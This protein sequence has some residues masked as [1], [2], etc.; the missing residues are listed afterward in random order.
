MT[1]DK[2]LTYLQEQTENGSIYVWGGQGQTGSQITEEWI[3]NRETSQQNARRAIDFWKKQ[4]AAGYESALRAFDCSGL[5]MYFLQNM[6]NIYKYDMSSASMHTK[7][8]PVSRATVKK[9]DWVFRKNSK[10][11]VYH[12]GFVVDDNLNVIEAMG[13]DYGVVKRHIDADKGYWTHFGRPECFKSE[14]ESG[15]PSATPSGEVNDKKARIKKVQQALNDSYN[16][17]LAVDGIIGVKTTAAIKAHL[18]RYTAGKSLIRNAYTGFV[19][20]R[21]M[22]LGYFIGQTG[23]DHAYGKN[24]AAAVKKFQQASKIA[25]DGIV[26]INTINNLVE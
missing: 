6:H 23:I 18:L 10:D 16:T 7:C 19:Q 20:E 5:G 8:A 17:K 1:L 25:V 11:Q 24:T 26:G 3:K 21:L 2:F 22:E 9:G 15:A 14:I 4:K 13:R 12:I